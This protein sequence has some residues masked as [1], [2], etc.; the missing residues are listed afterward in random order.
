[1]GSNRERVS[2]TRFASGERDR[3]LRE[4]AWMKG[5]AS[6][7]IHPVGQKLPNAWGFYDMHGN[8]GEWV[9]DTYDADIYTP[10]ERSDAVSTRGDER[11]FRGGSADSGPASMRVTEPN[12]W[13]LGMAAPGIGLRLARS[14]IAP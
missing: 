1:M 14:E 12:N 2:L 13:E 10:N 11:V 4:M 9:F 3:D 6:D 5:N 8:V 7:R